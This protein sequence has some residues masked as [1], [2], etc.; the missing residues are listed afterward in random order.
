MTSPLT[1]GSVLEPQF[2]DAKKAA[3]EI[4]VKTVPLAL[5]AVAV[6]PATPAALSTQDFPVTSILVKIILV[7][8]AFVTVMQWQFF[9]EQKQRCIDNIP[10][11]NERQ[12]LKISDQ[13]NETAERLR[14]EDEIQNGADKQQLEL[15]SLCVLEFLFFAIISIF[16]LAAWKLA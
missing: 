10:S 7:L 2:K 12:W 9:R 16:L 1:P 11:Q 15:K 14:F 8:L 4:I 3:M 13:Y 5:T 6:V